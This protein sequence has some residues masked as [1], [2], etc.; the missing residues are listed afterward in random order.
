LVAIGIVLGVLAVAMA[1]VRD[2]WHAAGTVLVCAVACAVSGM[3]IAQAPL[4]WERGQTQIDDVG[5]VEEDDGGGLGRPE[6]PSPVR[7]SPGI[8]WDAFD[9]AR[10]GWWRDE[11]VRA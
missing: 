4:P 3:W 5:A 9:R 8:D 10:A 1:G 11:L 6:N 2:D 7:P